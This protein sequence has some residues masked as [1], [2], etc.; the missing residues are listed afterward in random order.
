MEE[1]L[2]KVVT[3]FGVI[4]WDAVLTPVSITHVKIQTLTAYTGF[5]N[6]YV[7]GIRIMRLQRVKP[8]E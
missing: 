6:V 1:F 2:K 4:R 3:L 5:T 8:W 7:F